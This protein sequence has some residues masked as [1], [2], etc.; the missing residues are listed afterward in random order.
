M[1]KSFTLVQLKYFTVVA[2]LENMR[3]AAFELDVTQSTL[4]AAIHK[5]ESEVGAKLFHRRSNRGLRLTAEGRR[6]LMGARTVL[7]DADQLY[8]SVR[9]EREELAGD[10]VAGIF[11]PIA[12]FLAPR[13]LTA[14]Q[15]QHPAIRLSFLE[16]DQETLMRSL[17][18]GTCE[19]ALMYDLGLSTSYEY[20]VLRRVPPHL[21]VSEN[22]PRARHPDVPVHLREFEDEPFVLLD[23]KHSREYYLDIFKRLGL[24]PRIRHLVSGYE[25]VRSYV[26]MGHGYSLL[27]WRL[28]GDVTYAG[29]RVVPLELADELA[30]IE[31]VL[32]RLR[33]ARTTR[34]S[35]AFEE[36][37]STLHSAD[38]GSTLF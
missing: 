9:A 5:L 30:P 19:T 18:E 29:G 31:L 13:I 14:F 22:H 27:N 15:H 24:R 28:A 34:K 16:A 33:G 4:S 35:I 10:L 36:I 1:A 21:L 20:R 3:A 6:L 37:C 2:R 25:T 17:A 11:S 7:E 23:L 12:P 38:S 8:R 26:S 32:V